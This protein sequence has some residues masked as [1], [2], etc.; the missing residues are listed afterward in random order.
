MLDLV[1]PIQHGFPFTSGVKDTEQP[2]FYFSSSTDNSLWKLF[3][4]ESF[5]DSKAFGTRKLFGLKSFLDSEAFWTRKLFGL[6]SFL[7]SGAF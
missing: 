1:L 4:L 7:D 2:T 5:L 3:G 6:G